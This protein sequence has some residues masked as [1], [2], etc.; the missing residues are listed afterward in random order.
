MK[1]I[2]IV[3]LIL[4]MSNIAYSESIKERLK[5]ARA[6]EEKLKEAQSQI[7][8]PDQHKKSSEKTETEQR[9]E[10]I[11]SKFNSL[12]PVELNTHVSNSMFNKISFDHET[13]KVKDRY[14]YGLT[15]KTPAWDGNLIFAHIDTDRN[16]FSGYQIIPRKDSMKKGF[17]VIRHYKARGDAPLAAIQNQQVFVQEIPFDRIS[18]GLKANR[19]YIIFFVSKINQ[20]FELYISL[21]YIKGD[22]FQARD[23]LADYLVLD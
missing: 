20:P 4:L 21:N 13:I 10:I 19:Q 3:W 7:Y 16:G 5:R 23:I 22:I 12:I 8:S 9:D 1:R 15:F 11:Q 6:E 18:G 14:Y 2:I 17:I